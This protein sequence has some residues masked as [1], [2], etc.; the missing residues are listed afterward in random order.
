MI[1]LDHAYINACEYTDRLIVCSSYY[2]TNDDKRIMA[3]LVYLDAHPLLSAR[4]DW[5]LIKEFAKFIP[6][7]PEKQFYWGPGNALAPPGATGHMKKPK[8][9]P[10]RHMPILSLDKAEQKIRDKYH[11]YSYR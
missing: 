7:L 8:R 4:R 9:K 2:N 5:P 6:M 10:R 11:T 3:I 1:A